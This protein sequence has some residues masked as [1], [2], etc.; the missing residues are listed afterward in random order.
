MTNDS[1]LNDDQIQSNSPTEADQNLDAGGEG[2]RDT[3]DE[4]TEEADDRDA[5]GEGAADTGDES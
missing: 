3:G 1:N 2:P 4:P 5:G